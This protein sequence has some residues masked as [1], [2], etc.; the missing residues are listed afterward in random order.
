[1]AFIG[2]VYCT[3]N[4]GKAVKVPVDFRSPKGFEVKYI[5]PGNENIHY[6]VILPCTKNMILSMNGS[7]VILSGQARL[8]VRQLQKMGYRVQ[9]VKSKY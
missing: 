7:E 8:Q 6:H 9:T 1:M 3:D 4:E 5:P 2:V